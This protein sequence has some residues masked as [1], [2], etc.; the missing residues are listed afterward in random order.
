[1]RRLPALLLAAGLAAPA[2][3]AASPCP[4]AK[5]PEARV[6]TFEWSTA[7]SKGRLGIMVTSLT[8][9]LRTHYGA[10]SDRGVLVARVEPGS[11]AAGAGLRVGDVVT[12]VRGR[13]IDDAPEVIAALAGTRK[14]EKVELSIIR[15][16]QPMTVTATMTADAGAMPFAA[17]WDLERWFRDFWNRMPARP[18]PADPQT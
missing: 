12:A 7:S 3:V 8:P 11:A 18:E 15:D 4:D 2:S 17:P 16:K 5:A 13:A 1:M 9:E 14:G 10:A 6:Q